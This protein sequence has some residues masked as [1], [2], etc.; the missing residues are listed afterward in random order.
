MFNSIQICELV[1]FITAANLHFPQIMSEIGMTGRQ[2]YHIM[3][4]IFTF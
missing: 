4:P 1:A 2:S 3:V